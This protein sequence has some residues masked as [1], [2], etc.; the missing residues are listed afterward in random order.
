[1]KKSRIKAVTSS[2]VYMLSIDPFMIFYLCVICE[3]WQFGLVW[4]YNLLFNLPFLLLYCGYPGFWSFNL[5]WF[6]IGFWKFFCPML[7]PLP[8]W[9]VI[10]LHY[11]FSGHIFC[12][13][14]NIP[15]IYKYFVLFEFSLCSQKLLIKSSP[16]LNSQFIFVPLITFIVENSH[17]EYDIV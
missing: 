14:V 3:F 16:C 2:I 15:F 7:L 10:L 8:H 1:M 5:K 4:S 9:K 13:M 6:Q 12:S 11:S 17:I